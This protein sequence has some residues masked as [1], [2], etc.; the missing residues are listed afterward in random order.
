[1]LLTFAANLPDRERLAQV[2][3]IPCTH[4]LSL[5]HT[6]TQNYVEMLA[7]REPGILKAS[8]DVEVPPP[9]LQTNSSIYPLSHED[10]P[11]IWF[12]PT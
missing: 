12:P 1:M 4:T 2:L 11:Y 7:G 3:S 9:A 5:T 8:R 6:Y 10:R